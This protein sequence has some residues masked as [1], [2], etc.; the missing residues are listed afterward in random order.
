MEKFSFKGWW[1]EEEKAEE[2]NPW[3]TFH[4]W[5]YGEEFGDYTVSPADMEALLKASG[6][7]IVLEKLPA[8]EV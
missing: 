1:S 4:I 7:R 8:G 5:I 2:Q 6:Y 3:E